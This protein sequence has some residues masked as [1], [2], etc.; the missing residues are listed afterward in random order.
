MSGR[1]WADELMPDAQKLCGSFKQGGQVP[2]EIEV[3]VGKLKAIVDL[4]TLHGD[5]P[6]PEPL[7]SSFQAGRR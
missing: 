7:G 1:I 5:A 2:L 4:D 6:S 3:A